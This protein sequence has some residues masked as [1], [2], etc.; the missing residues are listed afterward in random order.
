MAQSLLTTCRPS[1]SPVLKCG[2]IGFLCQ[3]DAQLFWNLWKNNFPIFEISSILHSKFLEYWEKKTPIFFV[4]KDAQ[5]SETNA[6]SILRFLVFEIWSISN[7]KF[8][9]NRRLDDCVFFLTWFRNANQWYPI[10]RQLER[11]NP[12]ISGAWD[13]F[14][15]LIVRSPW[16]GWRIWVRLGGEPLK[17]NIL[18][19]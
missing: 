5:C 10:T 1:P 18:R 12:K 13:I 4:P 11:Y 19:L 9:V 15:A 7:S 14:G 6:K 3:K 8:L 17:Y 16:I 2:P